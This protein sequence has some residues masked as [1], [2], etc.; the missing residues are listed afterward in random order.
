MI[1]LKQKLTHQFKGEVIIKECTN[2]EIEIYII[3]DSFKNVEIKDRIVQITNILRSDQEFM[4]L[5]LKYD[6]TFKPRTKDEYDN[7]CW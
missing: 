7:I 5:D 3:S 2:G 6:F 4:D 1:E